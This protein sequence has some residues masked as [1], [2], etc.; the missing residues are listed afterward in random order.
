MKVEDFLES[1]ELKPLIAVYH[2][3]SPH[4][5]HIL[6]LDEDMASTTD[7]N[8]VSIS[9]VMNEQK[10]WRISTS[11]ETT[12]H[13]VYGAISLFSCVKKTIGINGLNYRLVELHNE[14]ELAHA[15]SKH[16]LLLLVLDK[17]KKK[18]ISLRCKS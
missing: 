5:I 16:L 13:A 1:M 4:I 12:S 17:L 15:N 9:K 7:K 2:I 14:N 11:D 10:D 18:E 6:T 8:S 3:S